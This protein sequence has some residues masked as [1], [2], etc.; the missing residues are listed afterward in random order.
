MVLGDRN[1]LSRLDCLPDCFKQEIGKLATKGQGEGCRSNHDGSHKYINTRNN[2]SFGMNKLDT[3]NE[4]ILLL[5]IE[6]P[7]SFQTQSPNEFIGS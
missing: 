5:T 1:N 7:L 6:D 2:L 4:S 3:H